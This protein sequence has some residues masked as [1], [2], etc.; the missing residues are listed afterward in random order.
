VFAERARGAAL[1]ALVALAVGSC[2]APLDRAVP[3]AAFRASREALARAVAL[4]PRAPRA[5]VEVGWGEVPI[6]IVPGVSL[7]GYGSRAGVPH[8]G[9][10]DRVFAR[11]LAV[12]AGG[13]P[14]VFLAL[15]LLLVDRGLRQSLAA[16]L[17]S[18]VSIGRVVL[19]ASHSHGSVGGYAPGLVYSLVLGDF[20]AR[21]HDAV[22]TAA[23]AA[24]ASAVAALEP[25][26]VVLGEVEAPGLASNRVR[27]SGAPVDPVAGVLLAERTRDGARA[28]LV[29]YAAHATTVSDQE[30]RVTADYPG[31]MVEALRA[32]GLAWA[33][34]AA[35]AVGSMAPR[36]GW[37]EHPGAA[38]TGQAL[39]A[40]VGSQLPRL[41]A[42]LSG[43]S[44]VVALASTLV[45]P[46]PQW[47]LG[48]TWAVPSLFAS[49]FAPSEGPV[50]AV[51]FGSATWVALPLELSG[52]ISR[53][54]RARARARG[55]TLVLSA[56]GG[57]YAGYVVPSAA[58]DLPPHEAGEMA[59]YE[60]HL[61]SFYGPH[62][63][64]LAAAAAW[65]TA[66]AAASLADG[67]SPAAPLL[68][69]PAPATSP[70]PEAP[71]P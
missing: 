45:L 11:A 30:L 57:E 3:R 17:A 38:W 52:E 53:S 1:A 34:F 68:Q 70:P 25:G 26:K 58:Y 19:T 37:S 42:R 20:D 59:E 54:L 55:H 47:R 40:A 36:A 23:A 48:D 18:V 62:M 33:A 7:A 51:S 39:A 12:R 9:V 24:V 14:V 31:V 43:E 49:W 63:G 61:M 15:D 29:S 60:T 27:K 46:E 21:A 32:Q 64:D 5:S 2:A 6:E 28:A 10:H 50:V 35:G 41:A 69:A 67:V 22:V 4:S 65:R 71:R 44:P 56:F 66:W 8:T 16:R 13:E